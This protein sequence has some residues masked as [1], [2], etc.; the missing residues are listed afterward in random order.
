MGLG[1]LLL[2]K[3]VEQAR[4][5]GTGL[6]LVTTPG[7]RARSFYLRNGWIADGFVQW[8]MPPGHGP[9]LSRPSAS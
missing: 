2:T 4:A 5:A 8:R 7:T 6:A 3:L 1:K 9:C